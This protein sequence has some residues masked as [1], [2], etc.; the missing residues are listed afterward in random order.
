[1]YEYKV[2]SIDRVVDGDTVYLTI[3]LG[4][5]VNYRVKLRIEGIDAPEIRGPERPQG[6]IVKEYAKE[7]LDLHQGDLILKTTRKPDKYGRW[8]GDIFMEDHQT[9]LGK[10]VER[11]YKYDLKFTK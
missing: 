8:L 3:D 9:T 4:F 2:K 10:M 1:M 6:M 7:L 11:F 5:Y